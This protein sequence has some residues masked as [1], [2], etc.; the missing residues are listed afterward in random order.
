MEENYKRALTEVD[1]ILQNTDKE[2]TDKI[3]QK[4]FEFIKNMKIKIITFV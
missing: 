2:I 3:P 4:F 1:C